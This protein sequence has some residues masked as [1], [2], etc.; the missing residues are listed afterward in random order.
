MDVDHRVPLAEAYDSGAS[1]WTPKEREDSDNDLG[2][3]RSLITGADHGTT[4]P[5]QAAA[6]RTPPLPCQEL[7]RLRFWYRTRCCGGTTT[8]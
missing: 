4:D 7:R 2:D 6:W 5:R 1:A 3:A 8:W